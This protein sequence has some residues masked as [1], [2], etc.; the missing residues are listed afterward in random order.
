MH[1][2]ALIL[3]VVSSL[4]VT[5]ALP[6]PGTGSNDEN[7]RSVNTPSAW[8]FFS[9]TS[10]WTLSHDDSRGSLVRLMLRSGLC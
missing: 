6:V 9:K 1:F 8:G 10:V 5:A 4:S 7:G 2:L 3:L